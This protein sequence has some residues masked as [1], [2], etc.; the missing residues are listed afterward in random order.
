MTLDDALDQIADIRSHMANTRVFRGYRCTTTLF[1]SVLAITT[2]IFQALY[3]PD[4]VHHVET[5][6][7]LWLAVGSLCL[8]VVACGM[9]IRYRRSDSPLD[10]E[11]AVQAAYQFLPCLLT[12]GLFTYVLGEVA[13]GTL[14]IIPGIWAM[15]F[16]HGHSRVAAVAAQRHCVC[17]SLLFNLRRP[18][19]CLCQKLS[20]F[21]SLGHGH[22]LRWGSADGGG[23]LVLAVGAKT[24]PE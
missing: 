3:L 6:L 22:P 2:S 18:F 15:L 21:L 1:S 23:Y 17:G 4:A 14:W 16:R 5:F 13:W 7:V 19:H 8:V 12:G 9:L 24:W 20:G 10:R 11:L